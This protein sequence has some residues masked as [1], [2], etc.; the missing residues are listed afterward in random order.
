[1]ALSR[2]RAFSTRRTTLAVVA[3]LLSSTSAAP[4]CCEAKARLARQHNDAN[5]LVLPAR[6]LDEGAC[7]R[8]AIAFLGTPFSGE[9]HHRRRVR[10]LGELATAS[11]TNTIMAGN[12]EKHEDR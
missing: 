11:S 12:T 9:E 8:I 10:R 5:V 2:G 1:M 3:T 6:L 7:T 4:S